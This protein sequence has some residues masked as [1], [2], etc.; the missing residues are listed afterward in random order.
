MLELAL[1][2]RP[3]EVIRGVRHGPTRAYLPA[4]AVAREVWVTDGF[5]N[6]YADLATIFMHI[7][8]MDAGAWVLIATADEFELGKIDAHRRKKNAA[9]LA[10]ATQGE[11]EA[12]VCAKPV[13]FSRHV[14]ELKEL[15]RFVTRQDTANWRDGL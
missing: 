3:H 8:R 1:E 11:C 15:L 2:A 9:L 10:L 7:A 13:W 5:K 4:T 6:A 14:F 12:V